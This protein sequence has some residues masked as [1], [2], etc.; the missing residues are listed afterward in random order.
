M[1]TKVVSEDFTVCV[2]VYSFSI[3]IKFIT[4]I[5]ELLTNV[6]AH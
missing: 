1:I 4:L 5:A 2:C 3:N 6:K